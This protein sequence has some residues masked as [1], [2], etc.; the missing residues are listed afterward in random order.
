MPN[1]PLAL[2][3]LKAFHILPDLLRINILFFPTCVVTISNSLETT[4]C[5]N[6]KQFSGFRSMF[7][8]NVPKSAKLLPQTIL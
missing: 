4:S 6:V 2:D 1:V 3:Q 7:G 8:C 5:D